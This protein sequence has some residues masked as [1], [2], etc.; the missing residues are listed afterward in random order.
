MKRLIQLC[1][2]FDKK[3]LMKTTIFSTTT[4]S[5]SAYAMRIL[6]KQPTPEGPVL[7]NP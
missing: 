6:Y 1:L 7:N 2:K 5:A 3:K 4:I